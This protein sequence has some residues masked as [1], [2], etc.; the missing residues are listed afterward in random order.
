MLNKEI[1]KEYVVRKCDRLAY[2]M[3]HKEYAFS[4]LKKLME[5]QITLPDDM[6][7][8]EDVDS[9]KDRLVDYIKLYPEAYDELTSLIGID[10]FFF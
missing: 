2:I 8:D 4:L 9:E 3:S 10:Y 5:S 6:E 1:L 7:D